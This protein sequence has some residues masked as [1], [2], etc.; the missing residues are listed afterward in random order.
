M[1]SISVKV[2]GG[3]LEEA[4]R[5]AARL[6]LPL[7]TPADYY[8]YL[9]PERLELQQHGSKSGA[10]YV[11]FAASDMLRRIADQRREP[12]HRAMAV[13]AKPSVIDA[14]AGLGEDALLLAAA[15][16][17][18]T[19]LERSAIVAA[20]L[21]DGLRRATAI[22]ELAQ[23]LARLRLVQGDARVL[24]PQLARAQV[25]YL[26]PMYPQSG[27][28]AAKRKEM[29]VFRRL[30]GD[31]DDAAELLELARDFALERV[32]VKRPLKAAP[33]GASKPTA[34][35]KGR[36]TRFDIYAVA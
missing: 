24:L 36:T 4:S 34:S 28:S 14:T 23:S 8:L 22:P 15:G 13:K 18:V 1:V 3:A 12:L 35:L 27:K 26:D 10:V 25:I 2:G 29:T 6:Q 9:S 17:Q 19:M 30:L 7:G 31:D 33:L 21:E 5:L 32:V 11:D 20:L 16:C